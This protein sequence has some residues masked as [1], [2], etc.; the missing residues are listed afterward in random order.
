MIALEYTTK[1]FPEDVDILAGKIGVEVEHGIELYSHIPKAITLLPAK[2]FF[3]THDAYV[4]P[5]I[6]AFIH[7]TEDII[8]IES[9]TDEKEEMVLPLNPPIFEYLYK[10]SVFGMT[11][12]RKATW[13]E[14][15]SFWLESQYKKSLFVY[16]L[17]CGMRYVTQKNNYQEA[18][19][20]QQFVRQTITAIKRFLFGFTKISEEYDSGKHWYD[21]F[22][23]VEEE[24]VKEML[25]LPDCDESYNSCIDALWTP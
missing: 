16:L 12:K 11:N 20:G 13:V 6:E 15:S 8:D 19:V 23:G 2:G 22:I 5:Q 14:P 9:K 21:L 1:R 17:Y 7:H 10:H 25:I 4:G 18:L 24:L 3:I